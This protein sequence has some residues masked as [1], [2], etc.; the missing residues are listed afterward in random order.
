M[1]EMSEAIRQYARD[2]DE[3]MHQAPRLSSSTRHTLIENNLRLVISIARRY[4]AI[5][6]VPFLDLV[7]EGNLGLIRATEDFNP[8]KGAF[9]THA[10]WWIKQGIRHAMYRERTLLTVPEYLIQRF[11]HLRKL[12]HDHP[13]WTQEHLAKELKI[14]VATLEDLD[15]LSIEVASIHNAMKDGEEDSTLAETL[16]AQAEE[17][18]PEAVVLKASLLAVL[19]QM[20]DRLTRDE[21][22]VIAL[23]YGFDGDDEEAMSLR[24]IAR[25]LRMSVDRVTGLEQRAMLKMRTHAKMS[26]LAEAYGVG[27]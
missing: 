23:R 18:N 16:E 27:A 15:H 12:Q 7:Q 26:H 10:T 19:E 8:E 22:R 20:L 13:E 9:S 24:D 17:D 2:I 14:S 3:H 1:I 4:A 11:Q 21:R 25:H 6:P 5:S